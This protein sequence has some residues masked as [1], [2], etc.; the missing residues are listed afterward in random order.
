MAVFTAI[1]FETSGRSGGL[2]CALGL[3]TFENGQLI[4]EYYSLIRPSSSRVMFTHIHGLRWRDLK[5]APDFAEV[6]SEAAEFI[7]GAQYLAAHNAPFDRGV[8]RSCCEY[9]NIEPPEQDFLCTWKGA[10]KAL[11]I[12][13]FNLQAVCDYFGF[14]LNHHQALSDAK[15]CGRI[16]CKLLKMGLTPND[17]L[18]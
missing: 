10:K 7:K 3:A 11:L 2:A 14:E 16:L 1:D 17:M 12:E 18:R 13:S 8:L 9:Y 6:W 15:N 4:D 5:D